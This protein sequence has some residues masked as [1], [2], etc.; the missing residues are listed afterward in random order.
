MFQVVLLTLMGANNA[1]REV[2]AERLIFEKEKLGGVSPAAYL[3]SKVA[4]LAILAG[5]QALW[6]AS[7]V[8]LASGGVL[9]GSFGTRLLLLLF[10]NFAVTSV[11]L[12]I[13]SLMR[14]PE[15]STLL[16]IYLVGFQLPLSGAVLAL[17]DGLDSVIHPFIAAY[18]SWSGSLKTMEDPYY[19][20][21]QDVTPENYIVTPETCLFVLGMHVIIGLMVAYFGCKRSRWD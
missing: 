20:A 8:D 4:F 5:A 19:G 1:A 12:G 3:F 10:V 9:P 21:V 7:F 17:P 18:W 16:S 14:S 13:S 6:M 2:A 11:C 15:Q